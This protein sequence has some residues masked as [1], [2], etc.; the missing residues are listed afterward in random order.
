MYSKS[1]R[2]KKSNSRSA[3]DAI[4]SKCGFNNFKITPQLCKCKS[5]VICNICGPQ[6]QWKCDKV[7]LTLTLVFF[8]NL[9]SLYRMNV[10]HQQI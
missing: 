3:E 2:A 7:L 5:E 9:K 8:Y 4:C 1:V 10:V 6:C